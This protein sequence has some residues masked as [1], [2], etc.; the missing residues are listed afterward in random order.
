MSEGIG[1][2]R[3]TGRRTGTAPVCRTDYLR[4]PAEA[5]MTTKGT[6]KAQIALFRQV[7]PGLTNA[8]Q[9]CLLRWA[10]DLSW[11]ETWKN[12]QTAALRHRGWHVYWKDFIEAVL[13]ARHLAIE[14]I[15]SSDRVT[16]QD[17]RIGDL[18][19]SAGKRI[20]KLLTTS[21]P[22][23]TLAQVLE[24]HARALRDLAPTTLP[25]TPYQPGRNDRKGSRQRK[26]FIQAM[27][28]YMTEMV[29]QP[30]DAVVAN[31]TDI[32]FNRRDT[33]IEQVR[34]ARRPTTMSGRAR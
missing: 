29:G 30:L 27:T 8:E 20:G 32:M 25:D 1:A 11:E 3:L 4:A 34:A 16:N 12:I 24:A 2:A 7:Y 26:I 19:K 22:V 10:N 23:P 18:L 14:L 9:Q 31:L 21:L 17:Q 6:F 15:E 5:L 13:R 28:V 33:S